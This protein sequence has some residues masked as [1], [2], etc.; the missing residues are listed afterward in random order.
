MAGMHEQLKEARNY[1]FHV[2]PYDLEDEG[3][4]MA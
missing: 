4:V 2:C 1:N 3:W